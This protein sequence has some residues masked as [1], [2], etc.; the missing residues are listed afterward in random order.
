MTDISRRDRM[1]GGLWGAVVGDALGVPVEFKGRDARKGDPVTDMRGY[2]TFSL[3]PGSWSDDSSLM[4]CTAQGL[5]DGFDT[6]RIGDLFVNWFTAGLWTPHGQAFDV[7]RG[8]WQ[9][10]SRMQ[11]GTPAESAGGR[12]ESNNGNGSLMRILPVAFYSATMGDEE[13]LRLAH[14]ASAVTHGHPRSVI[15]CGVYCLIVAALLDGMTP[16]EA[17]LLTMEKAGR[18]YSGPSF[19]EELVHFSRL[20]SGDIDALS[21]AA[22]ESDGYV[23]H[24]LEASLWCL[25]TTDSYGSAVLKAVNLGW[26]TDTTAIVTGGLA[27]T[28]YGLEAVPRQWRDTLARKQEIEALFERFVDETMSG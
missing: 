10:I 1:L 18:L 15:A 8:T 17:Y 19:S 28:H 20:L 16:R 11:L 21:E 4:L 13:A 3:P 22:I 25:L 7:G 12:E 6:E 23:V 27:G 9:A 2:G 24:T 14:R 5:L 26:D